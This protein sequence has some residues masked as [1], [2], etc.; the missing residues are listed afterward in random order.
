MSFHFSFVFF[1][2]F[3]AHTSL[4]KKTRKKGSGYLGYKA[5]MGLLQGR[6]V[7][8]IFF[9]S[10]WSSSLLS[11]SLT[12]WKRMRETLTSDYKFSPHGACFASFFHSHAICSFLSTVSDECVLCRCVFGLFFHCSVIY[13]AARLGVKILAHIPNHVLFFF[14]FPSPMMPFLYLILF[15]S[16]P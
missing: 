12:R 7:V 11:S 4:Q 13:M 8:F 16:H 14:S 9:C 10:P 1:F 3:F 15:L 6:V 2:F 5:F